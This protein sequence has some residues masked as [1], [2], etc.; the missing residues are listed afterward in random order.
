MSQ[1]TYAEGY[2]DQHFR[3]GNKALKSRCGI[4][5][6]YKGLIYESMER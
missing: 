3:D 2:D 5:L 1:V 6:K 4:L